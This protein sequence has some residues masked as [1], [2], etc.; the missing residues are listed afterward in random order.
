AGTA[1]TPILCAIENKNLTNTLVVIVRY[2]G[3]I[4]LGSSNLYRAYSDTAINVLN[5]NE[6]V[7]LKKYIKFNLKVNYIDYAMLNTFSNKSGEVKILDATFETS[8]EVNVAV[9]ENCSSD[10]INNLIKDK[11]PLGEIWL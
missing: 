11:E 8:V 10:L 7:E 3:G 4:L 1:G 6:V 2:F 9:V 5:A